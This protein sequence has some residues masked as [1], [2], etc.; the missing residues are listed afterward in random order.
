MAATA[1]PL[2]PATTTWTPHATMPPPHLRGAAAGRALQEGEEG[3]GE[4]E[5]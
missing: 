4:G 2:L 5:E 3:G 1:T